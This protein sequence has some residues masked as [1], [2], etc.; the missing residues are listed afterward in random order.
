[1]ANILANKGKNKAALECYIDALK[2]TN[3]SDDYKKICLFFDKVY[4]YE[5]SVAYLYLAKLQLQEGS[6]TEAEESLALAAQRSQKKES[7]E[8]LQ[9]ALREFQERYKHLK[10]LADLERSLIADPAQK[11]LY[12]QVAPFYD[13]NRQITLYLAGF[14][15]FYKLDPQ[16]GRLFYEKALQIDADKPLIY[17]T[18]LS[19]LEKDNIERDALYQNLARLFFQGGDVASSLAF[20]RKALREKRDIDFVQR[21]RVLWSQ[22]DQ[23]AEYSFQPIESLLKEMKEKLNHHP[24]FLKLQVLFYARQGSENLKGV[25][26]KLGT[27]LRLEKNEQAQKIDEFIQECFKKVGAPQ[28]S[29]LT[30]EMQEPQS[31]HLY[32]TLED[33]QIDIPKEASTTKKRSW[34]V[35]PIN[36]PVIIRRP[37]HAIPPD[38]A[39]L[40]PSDQKQPKVIES[41]K[42]A[43][44][45]CPRERVSTFELHCGQI[46][47]MYPP[48]TKPTAY[49]WKSLDQVCKSRGAHLV[50]QL[51]ENV[52]VAAE[53]DK[54][55]VIGNN[56]RYNSEWEIL[57]EEQKE[58]L[59]NSLK[60]QAIVPFS[61]DEY[62][63]VLSNG[64]IYVAGFF[65][66]TYVRKHHHKRIAA[67]VGVN[68]V[69]SPQS[70]VYAAGCA[71]NTIKIWKNRLKISCEHVLEGHKA[72]VTALVTYLKDFLVSGDRNGTIMWWNPSVEKTKPLHFFKAH[73]GEVKTLVSTQNGILISGSSDGTIK[74][75]KLTT[76]ECLLTLQKPEGVEI[77]NLT[78][79]EDGILVCA[80]SNGDIEFW[81]LSNFSCF[82]ILSDPNRKGKVT[83]L[84]C[85][86]NRGII[87]CSEAGAR[88]LEPKLPSTLDLIK[89]VFGSNMRMEIGKKMDPRL[90]SKYLPKYTTETFW[91]KASL[92]RLVGISTEE[93]ASRKKLRRIKWCT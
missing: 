51:D 61:H 52:F 29:N 81:D 86:K 32:P 8:S 33:T 77:E 60:I 23:Q 26:E 90:V 11:E 24:E 70:S 12:D 54:I 83:A 40:P 84:F 93:E 67:K 36:D 89:D 25:L 7:I 44:P 48:S 28:L 43:D 64:T 47:Q 20:L 21:I 68:V 46:E 53:K 17:L 85:L 92:K 80:F 45:L 16:I 76:E 75:W 41:I 50:T 31:S 88:L 39:S 73:Q 10:K 91:E 30:P 34:E 63:V 74:F 13:K 56:E 15:T 57:K 37:A 4:P 71:D 69:I 9:V 6:L 55:K 66:D 22:R 87:V 14:C 72:P 18:Y 2:F 5:A 78:L 3:K 79:S 42:V 38:A 59:D 49:Q 62:A 58:S 1:M 35:S 82:S 65:D 19:H 27:M